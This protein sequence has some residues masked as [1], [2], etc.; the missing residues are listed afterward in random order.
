MLSIALRAIGHQVTHLSEELIVPFGELRRWRQFAPAVMIWVEVRPLDRFAALAPVD[1]VLLCQQVRGS[2]PVELVLVLLRF[3]IHEQLTEGELPKL[4]R[5]E[6]LP[7]R[8]AV[9]VPQRQRLAFV[10]V[11]GFAFPG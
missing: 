9:Q 10:F 5:L 3:Q 8:R 4:P 1:V 11:A 6:P 7:K 2:N